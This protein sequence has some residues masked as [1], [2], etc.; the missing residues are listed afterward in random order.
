MV[1]FRK[2]KDSLQ[3]RVSERPSDIFSRLPKPDYIDDLHQSQA[4][5]LESWYSKRN[6]CRDFILKLHTG[7]GKTLV[8]LLVAMSS[9]IE[10][11]KGA[12]YLVE[13]RQLVD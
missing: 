1:D 12:L 7:G 8:G 3:G 10:L 4:E 6:S 11:G 9:M 2:M 13:N 5:V